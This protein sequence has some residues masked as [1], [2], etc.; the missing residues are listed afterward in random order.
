MAL[1]KIWLNIKFIFKYRIK[2]VVDDVTISM[3]R[4]MSEVM[5]VSLE[6]NK[7]INGVRCRKLGAMEW[8]I[9]I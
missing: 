1:T 4:Q 6:T 3:E 9:R 5:W 2:C 7:S 8:F